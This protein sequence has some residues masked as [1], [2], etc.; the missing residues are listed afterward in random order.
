MAP[1]KCVLLM[2]GKAS[3][4]C[5]LG[6]RGLDHVVYNPASEEE[7]EGYE[8]RCEKHVGSDEACEKEWVEED[9]RKAGGF[10]KRAGEWKS[11]DR[12][13]C[14]AC[15]GL[16]RRIEDP[17]EGFVEVLLSPEE[18]EKVVERQMQ[19]AH[20]NEGMTSSIVTPSG[21]NR[22]SHKAERVP[23]PEFKLHTLEGDQ[24]EEDTEWHR[25][26]RAERLR[27][28]ERVEAERREV[29]ATEKRKASRKRHSRRREEGREA[30]DV[31]DGERR[32]VRR[33]RVDA[34][35]NREARR[36]RPRDRERDPEKVRDRERDKNRE[37]GDRP[38]R[39]RKRRRRE[40]TPPPEPG[41]CVIM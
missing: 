19:T 8:F 29:E 15:V 38:E 18:I 20:E 37:G 35:G 21:R 30:R 7:N 40:P 10:I 14:P 36:D 33:S 24:R 31:K 12:T 4:N 5:R 6:N 2:I 41:C 27:E 1:P 25:E 9:F 3:P 11:G 34:E 23:E 26:Q 22:K 17:E 32:R 39:K 28:E 13:P 16:T